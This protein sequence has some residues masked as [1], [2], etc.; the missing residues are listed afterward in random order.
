MA[1]CPGTEQVALVLLS[2]GI[3]SY[4]SLRL[5]KAQGYRCVGIHFNYGQK[6]SKEASIVEEICK[7]EEVALIK[8]ELPTIEGGFLTN[9]EAQYTAASCFLPGRNTVLLVQAAQFAYANAIGHLFFSVHKIA[10]EGMQFPDTT[11][12]YVVKMQ[13]LLDEGMFDPGR[14]VTIHAP[15]AALYK[16]QVIGLGRRLGAALE[17][18]SSCYKPTV[19]N[20]DCGVCGGCGLRK[21]GFSALGIAD[22]TVYAE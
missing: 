5:A 15:L 7:L 14:S 12:Q 20:V 4:V 11:Q 19:S 10:Y 22:P 16:S 8:K 6:T 9:D 13:S 17:I 21:S 2:G 18:T 3:D 1:F